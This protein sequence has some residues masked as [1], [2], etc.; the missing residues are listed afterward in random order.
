MNAEF[1]A[2]RHLLSQT[3][4]SLLV[5]F[6]APD[7]NGLQQVCTVRNAAVHTDVGRFDAELTAPGGQA[8]TD[9]FFA[10][11]DLDV[12]ET[13]GRS[14]L[15]CSR[16]CRKDRYAGDTSYFERRFLLQQHPN[17]AFS[18]VCVPDYAAG[19]L[20]I[21]SRWRQALRAASRPASRFVS[22]GF[23]PDDIGLSY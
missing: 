6:T 22:S 13:D 20:L 16:I 17:G 5:T 8:G 7:I 3:F 4:P 15:L 11:A 23:E 12:I 18:V 2:D 1:I 9:R 10:F 19:S 21:A 14:A